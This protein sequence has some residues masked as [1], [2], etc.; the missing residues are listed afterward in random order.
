MNHPNWFKPF[1]ALIVLL[2]G[3]IPVL[4]YLWIFNRFPMVDTVS[5]LDGLSDSKQDAILVDVRAANEFSKM[6]IAGS[7]NWPA[8]EIAS[9]NSLVD[10]PS[11][12]KEKKLFLIC[13]SGLQSAQATGRLQNLGMEQV[14]YVQGGLQKWIRVAALQ[15]ASLFTQYSYTQL[16]ESLY[17][18]MTM[19]EQ[20]AAVVSG[21]G[22]KPLHMI[23]SAI[24][25][26]ILLKQKAFDLR[27]LGW[28]MLIFLAAE[29]F[30]AINYIFYDHNSY[31][32]EYLHS[33]GMTMSFG[34]V[35]FAVMYGMDERL[36][37]LS[38]AERPCV[39]LPLCKGCVK[40]NQT[41]CN[42][43]KLIQWGVGAIAGLAFIPILARPLNTSYSTHILGNQYHYC[44]LLLSQYFESR[45]LPVI[46][47]VFCIGTLLTM[48]IN[49]DNPFPLIAHIFL[50]GAIGALGFSIFRLMLGAVYNNNLIWADFWEEVTELMFVAMAAI[51]LWIYRNGLLDVPIGKGMIFKRSE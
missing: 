26:F 21:F 28:G 4:I 35:I 44:R 30:C 51:V 9:L 43:H 32:A 16:S 8:G 15:P 49:R 10:M 29:T 25:G 22:F 18:P 23:L 6:H 1:I 5:A 17:I 7:Y 31:L 45:Y 50:A 14:F 34:F 27:T 12:L 42:M 41:S 33:Y 20:V 11:E 39:F 47:L 13:N 36:L 3:S 24:L 48:Q 38:A 40:Y 37:R 46:V 2:T 19:I